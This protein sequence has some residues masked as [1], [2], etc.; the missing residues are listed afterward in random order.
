MYATNR[1]LHITIKCSVLKELCTSFHPSL[2]E[3]HDNIS[4]FLRSLSRTEGPVHVLNFATLAVLSTSSLLAHDLQQRLEHNSSTA[5]YQAT[6][7]DVPPEYFDFLKETMDPFNRAEF[8]KTLA[9]L[10]ELERSADT[11]QQGK[12]LLETITNLQTTC[13]WVAANLRNHCEEQQ[14]PQPIS[15]HPAWAAIAADYQ[16]RMVRL[17]Y[18]RRLWHKNN[19]AQRDNSFVDAF[20][21]GETTSYLTRLYET[22]QSQHIV[23]ISGRKG[24][25]KSMLASMYAREAESSG[26]YSFSAWLNAN[27][28]EADTTS[29]TELDETTKV[30]GLRKAYL[31]LLDKQGITVPNSKRN[32]WPFILKKINSVGGDSALFIID[33]A[34]S[35]EAVEDYLPQ[36]RV[37]ITTHK[38]TTML[39]CLM[40]E[41]WSEEESVKY[42]LHPLRPLPSPSLREKILNIAR[43]LDRLPIALSLV[44]PYMIENEQDAD[45]IENFVTDFANHISSF[46]DVSPSYSKAFI[47]LVDYSLKKL[48]EEEK[49]LFNVMCYL[50]CYSIAC[51]FLD[52]FT[53]NRLGSRRLCR[54]LARRNILYFERM[55]DGTQTVTMHSMVQEAG[56]YL[57]DQSLGENLEATSSRLFF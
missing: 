24:V 14:P 48:N 11:S 15:S 34:L 38:K 51:D 23:V 50:P 36:G 17:N 8:S 6:L 41:A 28:A 49:N 44:K 30:E 21:L 43:S 26:S 46:G 20:P 27:A 53:F 42:L 57:L 18:Y 35:Y 1:K 2:Q 4:W 10:M 47:A 29:F 19:F 5:Y 40:L 37:I 13:V 9:I 22:L 54:E 16:N 25:G 3:R 12:K 7:N 39:P 55:D 52:Q 31:Q 45:S 32:N 33:N 56:R